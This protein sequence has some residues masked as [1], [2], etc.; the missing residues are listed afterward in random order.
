MGKMGNGGGNWG[1]TLGAGQNKMGLVG[2]G[3][4]WGE[5]GTQYPTIYNTVVNMIT[6][7]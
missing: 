2:G 6:S 7:M 5:G 3:C 1:K 4:T